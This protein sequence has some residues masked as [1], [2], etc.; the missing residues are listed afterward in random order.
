MSPSLSL[1]RWS[2]DD[3]EPQRR[4]DYYADALS[5]AIVPVHVRHN[6]VGDFHAYMEVAVMGDL[7]FIDRHGTGYGCFTDV[8]NIVENS[9]HLVLNR[10]TTWS[11]EHMGRIHCEPGDAVLCEMKHGVAC[12]S[13]TGYAYVHIKLPES[14]VRQW[15]P[16]PAL[17]VGT[18]LSSASGWARALSAFA[19]GLTPKFLQKSPLPLSLLIDQLGSL[20][21]L[22]AQERTAAVSRRPQNVR[23]RID[24]IKEAMWQMCSSPALAAADVAAAINMPLRSFH[25]CFTSSGITFGRTLTDMRVTQAIRMLQSPIY[26][27]LTIGEIAS[28]A[29]FCDSSH[30]TVTVRTRTGMTP[31]QLR[32]EALRS[33]R[34]EEMP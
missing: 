6:P 18:R 2:T 30:L 16:T 24:R 23:E 31:S 28:R 10:T 17:L 13:P 12:E 15:L 14:W 25:R 29:G 9:F 7:S 32:R 8:K 1:T 26:K 33:S 5:K 20:L 22:A 4:V 27:R 34:V 19:A 11:L 21:A 3:V